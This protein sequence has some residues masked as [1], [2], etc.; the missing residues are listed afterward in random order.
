MRLQ[1]V[2]EVR[3]PLDAR[4]PVLLLERLVERVVL[5]ARVLPAPAVRLDDLE[6]IRRGDQHLHEERIGIERDRRD[7]LVELRWCELRRLTLRRPGIVGPDGS[8]AAEI[9][10]SAQI[11]HRP[12]TTATWR[13][14]LLGCDCGSR[15]RTYRYT[16]RVPR[17]GP[18]APSREQVEQLLEYLRCPAHAV[19]D[20]NWEGAF[21]VPAMVRWPGISSRARSPTRCFSGLGLVPDAARRG[22]GHD[23]Q[24]APAQGNRH[25]RQE[26]QGAPG[27]LQPAA[28]TSPARSPRVRAP[29]SPTSMTTACWSRTGTRTGRPC[30]AR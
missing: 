24:G 13:L 15:F 10:S 19:V 22:R 27:R 11:P 29:T 1:Q 8:G 25:R 6:R 18:R 21:R 5:Q 14:S 4:V 3:E 20:S 17:A 12:T 30:S 7:H 26:L 2:G 9:T 28:R 16:V 23:R